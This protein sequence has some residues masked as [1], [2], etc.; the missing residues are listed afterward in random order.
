MNGVIIFVPKYLLFHYHLYILPRQKL[1]TSIS[2]IPAA[3]Q[4]HHLADDIKLYL[5]GHHSLRFYESKRI[6]L[7]TIIFIRETG[8]FS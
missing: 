3:N 4:L 1:D 2:N 8:R 5:Y 7:S 6:P